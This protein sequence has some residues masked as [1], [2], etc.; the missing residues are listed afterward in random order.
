MAP[1]TF[2]R[3]AYEIF[4][5]READEGGLA[6]YSREIASGVPRSNT[7]DCLLSSPELEDRLRP[8]AV[9]GGPEG[10][11]IPRPPEAG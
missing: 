5:G 3:Q 1:E 4:L 6:F 8:L 7:I 11:S 9:S 2:V 10:P